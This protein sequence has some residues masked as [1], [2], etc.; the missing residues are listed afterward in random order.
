MQSVLQ[1]EDIADT[2]VFK[3]FLDVA[4]KPKMIQPSHLKTVAS[5]IT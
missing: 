3:Y 1:L 2:I 5:T 4:P